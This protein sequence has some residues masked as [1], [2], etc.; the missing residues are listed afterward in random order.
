MQLF[1]TWMIWEMPWVIPAFVCPV[2]P[3]TTVE[4]TCSMTRCLR[5]LFEKVLFDRGL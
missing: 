1:H 5:S 4:A 2:L 3:L